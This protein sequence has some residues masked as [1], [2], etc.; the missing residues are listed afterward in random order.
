MAF[1]LELVSGIVDVLD[2]LSIW[3]FSVFLMAAF[4]VLALALDASGAWRMLGFL[5][6][7]LLVA[8]GVSWEWRISRTG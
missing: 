1:I 5:S 8:I 4:V 3:R 6:A 7:G 2:V